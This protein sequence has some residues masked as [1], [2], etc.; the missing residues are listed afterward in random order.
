MVYGKL[1][2]TYSI[3]HIACFYILYLSSE[4]TSIMAYFT[5]NICFSEQTT[6]L[7]STA[8]SVPHQTPLR[9]II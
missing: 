2:D 8:Y 5:Y 1:N 9:S 3:Q 7:E 6:F 4:C